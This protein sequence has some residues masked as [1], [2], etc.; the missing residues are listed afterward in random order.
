[1]FDELEVIGYYYCTGD[2]ERFDQ[3]EVEL[4]RQFGRLIE[5]PIVLKLNPYKESGSS[6][7]VTFFLF[8]FKNI[9]Q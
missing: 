9:F 4:Y 5:L 8:Y 6:S 1:M 3:D 2:D 7:K